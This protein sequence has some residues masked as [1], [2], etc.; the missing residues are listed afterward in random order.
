MLFMSLYFQGD[1][2]TQLSIES[3]DF[4][5]FANNCGINEQEFNACLKELTDVNLIKTSTKINAKK[6]TEIFIKI[7]PVKSLDK[8]LK[9][10]SFNSSLKQKLPKEKYLE[11]MLILEDESN[12]SYE[13]S[14][15]DEEQKPAEEKALDNEVFRGFYEG[16]SS[17]IKTE[18]SMCPKVMETLKNYASILNKEKL[19]QIAYMSTIKTQDKKYEISHKHFSYLAE[20]EAFV[21]DL[22]INLDEHKKFWGSLNIENDETI[23]KQFK[24]LFHKG[25]PCAVYSGLTGKIRI[26]EVL[27]IW[28]KSCV[29]DKGF[30]FPLMNALMSFVMSLLGKIPVN[31][32]IKVS[33]TL[34]T[35]YTGSS[36]SLIELVRNVIESDLNSGKNRLNAKPANT[37]KKTEIKSASNN[38]GELVWYYNG[39]S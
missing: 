10:K 13:L 17:L 34:H 1:I 3:Y 20:Q 5:K 11:L 27:N 33:E 9:D 22:T 26:P 12:V 36:T 4:K 18:F 23:K 2:N 16:V 6:E 29:Q 7:Q 39:H 30:S 28:I 25:N 8:L 21:S 38:I 19:H 15:T 31:Y 14:N 24:E 35:N 32:L 37:K